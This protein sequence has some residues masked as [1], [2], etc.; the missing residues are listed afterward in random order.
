MLRINVEIDKSSMVVNPA[1]LSTRLAAITRRECDV[2]K[3]IAFELTHRPLALF[4]DKLTR[5]LDK[6][7][8]A[9]HS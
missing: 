5:K 7:L 2:E 9:T 3:C 4:K 6:H 1:L 8:C